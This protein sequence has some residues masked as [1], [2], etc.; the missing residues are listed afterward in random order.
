MHAQAC[1]DSKGQ[2]QCGSASHQEHLLIRFHHC[3]Q[4]TAPSSPQSPKYKCRFAKAAKDKR[5]EWI[6]FTQDYFLKR[7][8]LVS[9]LLLVDCSIL[10]QE[11]DVQCANWLAEAQVGLWDGRVCV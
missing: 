2:V 4:H 7:K 3:I 5:I 9:V 6:S 1:K 8:T 10:P 11:V